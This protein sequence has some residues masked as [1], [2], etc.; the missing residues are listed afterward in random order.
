[1]P[2]L[3]K[4]LLSSCLRRS[5]NLVLYYPISSGWFGTSDQNLALDL[6][7]RFIASPPI[8]NILDSHKVLIEYKILMRLMMIEWVV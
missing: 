5:Y 8:R 4:V 7:P 3:E 6:A 1:M 2:T